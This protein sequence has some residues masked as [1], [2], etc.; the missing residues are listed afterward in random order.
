MTETV[1]EFYC[2]CMDCKV[3]TTTG[4]KGPIKDSSLPLLSVNGLKNSSPSLLS[5]IDLADN[6]LF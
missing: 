4:S 3:P 5:V 1:T 6:S 2:Q